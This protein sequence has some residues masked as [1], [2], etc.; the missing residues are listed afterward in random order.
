VSERQC[1]ICQR[2][3]YERAQVC[4]SCRTWLAGV[5]AQI[6]E[7]YALLPDAMLPA[8]DGGQRVSGSREAPLPLAVDALD[9]TLPARAATVHDPHGDQHGHQPVATILDTWVRDWAGHRREHLPEPTVAILAGWLRDRTEWACDQHPA[10]D[11]YADELRGLVRTL[12]IITGTARL[13]VRLPTPC[14]DCDLLSLIRQD[15]ADHVECTQCRRLWTEDEYRR[16]AVVLA[17]TMR[18][19]A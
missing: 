9:L 19:A 4:E 14:P 5:P 18:E 3:P 11:E 10:V 2:R 17:E 15:G 7:A 1:V 13:V 12:R 16:L 6:V 8:T